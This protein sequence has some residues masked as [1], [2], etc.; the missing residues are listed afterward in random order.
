VDRLQGDA[1]YL[2]D[3]LGS[4]VGLT[5]GNGGG[6]V[7]T[8]SYQP[9]GFTTAGTLNSVSNP[10]TYASG[11]TEKGDL[12]KFGNRYYDT[13]MGRW[14]QQDALGGPCQPPVP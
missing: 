11:L 5:D 2:L 6:L 4:V 3:A 9:Y 8:Y 1:H 10:F 7:D 14:T 12:V 13:V